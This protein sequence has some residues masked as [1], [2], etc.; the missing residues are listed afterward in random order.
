MKE[1]VMKD[2]QLLFGLA[3]A[4][5]LVVAACGGDAASSPPPAAASQGAEPQSFAEQVTAGQDLYGKN[6]A[7]CHGASG[8]GTSQGPRVVGLDKGALPLDPPPTAKVRRTQFKTVADVA[9]F[10]VA[11]MPAGRP[12]SLK[13][14]EYW[15]ILAFDLKANGVTLDKKLDLEVAKATPLH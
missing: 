15:S 11:N 14:H 12:G 8:E 7:T 9:A 3:C 10:A 1:N 2:H 13:E 5:A 6:C 4:A